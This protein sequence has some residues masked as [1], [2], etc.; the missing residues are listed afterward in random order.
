MSIERR[1]PGAR[2]RVSKPNVS[3]IRDVPLLS[4]ST[5]PPHILDS[6]CGAQTHKISLADVPFRRSDYKPIDLN[7]PIRDW[8]C[9]RFELDLLSQIKYFYVLVLIL[10][11]CFFRF[12]DDRVCIVQF[13]HASTW[14]I[15]PPYGHTTRL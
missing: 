1:N 8:Q 2:R 11:H 14:P 10:Y 13:Q 9:Q 6:A 5:H 4:S 3:S 15:R 7:N 12:N